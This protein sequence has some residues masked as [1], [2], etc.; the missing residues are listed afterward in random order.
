MKNFAHRGFSGRYPENTMLAFR[1]AIEA[2][3]DGI[4]NDVQYTKDGELV[5][6]HDETVDRT[7]D[8]VGYVRDYTLK[9]LRKLD[10]SYI[11]KGPYGANPIPTLREYFELL[12]G[13]GVVT[14]IEIK[15]GK[16]VYPGI[17]QKIYDLMMEMDMKDQVFFS[18]FN[19]YSL[20][21]MKA[22]D[23]TVKCG[24]LEESW[25][26]NAG[27]YTKAQG[28]ECWHPL[29]R[30]L[31]PETVKELKDNGIEINT[32][33][34]NDRASVKA[35]MDLGVDSVIGNFPDMVKEIIENK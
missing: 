31:T 21:R 7:T 15:S 17:E 30:T 6:I 28:I 9:E 26:V 35:M 18:S 27:A 13:T 22:I 11:H 12:K 25:I 3:A 2:G 33:T 16:Y 14:N 1:K 34:V 8:G 5:V 4:E 10:A 23:K 19:H 32:W 20:L 29:Y 24:F